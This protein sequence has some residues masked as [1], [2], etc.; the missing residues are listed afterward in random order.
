MPSSGQHLEI[1][2]EGA[3]EGQTLTD[4]KDAS[5]RP[6]NPSSGGSCGE[7][8]DGDVTISRR[9][10]LALL[11]SEARFRE[12]ANAIHEVLWILDVVGDKAL[13][14][15]PA[16]DQ[17]WGRSRARLFDDVR[18]W[19]SPV[20]E[21]DRARVEA[22]YWGRGDRPFELTFRI[23][24]SDGAVRWIRN[25]GFPIHGANGAVRVAG[26]STDI[27]DPRQ[28]H[29]ALVKTQRLLASI[30]NSS[31]DAII[32][33]SLE[34]RITTWNPAAER[35]F[36]HASAEAIGASPDALLGEDQAA[37]A[38]WIFERIRQG[39]TVQEFKTERRHKDGTV[40]AVSITASPIRDESGQIVGASTHAHNISESKELEGKLSAVSEQLRAV[41][42]TTTEFVISVDRNWR[43]GYQNRLRN[44]ADPLT[45]VG[46]ILWEEAPYLLA[47]SVERESRKAMQERKPCRFEEYLGPL[48]AW[49]SG[50]AY[51]TA[52]G[53]LILAQDDTE[54]RALDDQ[55]RGAQKM[56][57]IGQLAAGIAHEINTPIQFVGDS[58]RFFK[59]SWEHLAELLLAA[60]KMR[61]EA[62]AGAVSPGTLDRFDTCSETAEVDFLL[63]TIPGA[64]D[65]TLDGV[66]R[67]ARIVGA[68]KEFSHPGS[69]EKRAVDL[70]R[71]IETT[72][73]IS[74]NEWKHVAE[75]KM[76]LDPNL[77]LVPCFAGEINQVFLNLVVNASHAIGDVVGK[78]G[79][80]LG[81]ITLSTRSDGGWVEIGIADTGSGI[82]E[83]LSERVF[84][85]FFTTKEVGKGTG[86]GLTLAHAVVVKKHGGR[87]WFDSEVGK[88]T[89]FFVRLPLWTETV[90]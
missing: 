61:R 48:K 7:A 28:A 2:I 89:T 82:P 38:S 84:D 23:V 88:G 15:S 53:L 3:G 43:I 10:H 27:T 56:E 81:T 26:I 25:R 21:E 41:L 37:E 13:Y 1:A 74:R 63:E 59:D 42:E 64:I 86:Q 34:G 79:K 47:T 52:T 17:V 60:Q 40:I 49:I 24:R 8:V 19:L 44:G 5:S 77:P 45:V 72:V 58:T 80:K 29:E 55:L 67:V 46:R 62:G 22:E 31:P 30:V 35:I 69:Q 20:H 70:N 73:T 14:V 85:P 50:V 6:P 36:G 71:A 78:D 16:Y 90:N 39:L 33:Q 75:V 68:M 11:E 18:D 65:R 66:Q 4:E 32:S 87:I 12:L 9:S 54:K 83:H 51:P 76:N 57:A